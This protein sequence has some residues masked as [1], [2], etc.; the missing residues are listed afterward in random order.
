MASS[1]SS[2]PSS[3]PL[4]PPSPSVPRLQGVSSSVFGEAV[5]QWKIPNFVKEVK[6]AQAAK[7][8]RLMSDTFRVSAPA[9]TGKGK[10]VFKGFQIAL[11]FN[12]SAPPSQGQGQ[13]QGQETSGGFRLSLS[14]R[15]GVAAQFSLHV[16]TPS[17]GEWK[18]RV[19]HEVKYFSPPPNTGWGWKEYTTMEEIH[20]EKLL[21]DGALIIAC[22]VRCLMTSAKD[23]GRTL[24]LFDKDL[25]TQDDPPTL[26]K[27]LQAH[28]ESYDVTIVCPLCVGASPRDEKSQAKI[29]KINS[30]TRF[31]CHKVVLTARSSIF[32]AMFHQ[33]MV[34]AKTNTI[35]IE[36]M[37]AETLRHFINF[38][39]TDKLTPG[40]PLKQLVPVLAAAEKYNIQG[41]KSRAELRIAE[42]INVS[43]ISEILSM[44]ETH[45]CL[46][47]K[48][49]LVSYL[50]KIKDFDSVIVSDGWVDAPPEFIKSVLARRKQ[51]LDA[52]CIRR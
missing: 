44:A 11:E 49:H 42:F 2:P 8:D 7:E 34:E 22:H 17:G 50:S 30:E 18:R 15:D 23:L 47:I 21:S 5:F 20:K 52:G 29:P 4:P 27:E 37:S 9:P 45:N 43:N 16:V 46:L 39:Y 51:V 24:D 13:A 6:F 36:D 35:R 1:S 38:L 41:L 26:G 31:R 40:L 25:A 19:S 14:S 3:T 10:K 12:A 33:D 48:E 32:A 28:Q